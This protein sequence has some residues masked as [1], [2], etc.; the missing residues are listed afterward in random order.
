M[1]LKPGLSGVIRAIFHGREV[2]FDGTAREIRYRS[3]MA[4][5]AIVR[6]PQEF[7]ILVDRG[8]IEI[9]GQD[10]LLYLPLAGLRAAEG[11]SLPAEGGA[12]VVSLDF[13][14]LR[15]VWR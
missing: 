15:S 9:F 6:G 10:G 13:W 5:E 7:D 14:E 1:S 8:S 2:V 11:I 4:P 12:R 3:W